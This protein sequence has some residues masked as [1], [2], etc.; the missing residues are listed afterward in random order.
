MLTLEEL[1]I[2]SNKEDF[3]INVTCIISYRGAKVRAF[4]WTQL[5]RGMMTNDTVIFRQLH[6]DTSLY[7]VYKLFQILQCVS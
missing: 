1:K 7:F 3:H 5:Q 4:P 6:E 2:L